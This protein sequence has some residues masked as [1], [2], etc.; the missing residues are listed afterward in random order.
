M[1]MLRPLL[2]IKKGGWVLANKI[3]PRPCLNCQHLFE[4][5]AQRRSLCLKCQRIKRSKG[6]GR[7][8]DKG[9]YRR[10]R[11]ILLKNAIYCDECRAVG[12]LSNPLTVDHI[13]PLALG[14]S[15]ELHNLQVLCRSCNSLKGANNA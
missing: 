2:K 14:G 9:L 15:N 11:Q 8:Y 4:P 1:L 10:N 3:I 13:V 5:T 7:A 12:S 6:P